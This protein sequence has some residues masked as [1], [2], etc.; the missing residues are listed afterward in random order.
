[1]KA[2]F[3]LLKLPASAETLAGIGWAATQETCVSSAAAVKKGTPLK[4]LLRLLDLQAR[5]HAARSYNP[6]IHQ[7][8]FAAAPN[9]RLEKLPCLAVNHRRSALVDG[10]SVRRVHA[11]QEE[12]Q[13]VRE[14]GGR[15]DN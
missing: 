11:N 9:R 3:G 7:T 2:A 6:S 5:E 10:A 8:R 14:V 15:K 12:G 13:S 1:M 4:S